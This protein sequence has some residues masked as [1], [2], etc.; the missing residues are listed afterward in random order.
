MGK[1]D[2]TK[3]RILERATPLLNRHGYMSAPLS[4][5]MRVTGMQKG[6]IYN[7][8]ASKEDLALEAFDYA[9]EVI[10]QRITQALEGKTGAIERLRAAAGVFRAYAD[11]A[12]FPGGCP[13]LNVAI[14][15]DDAHPALR[16]RARQ[17]MDRWHGLFERI[18]ARGI[19]RGELR[20]DV[21]PA[22]VATV[23]IAALEGA[24]AMTNLHKD[25]TPMRRIL[26]HLDSYFDREL[27]Q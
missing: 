20:A 6:G 1:G 14:E 22:T 19:E 18:V 27:R 3:R 26:A 25:G 5:I 10:S 9:I 24:V 7:H 12:P 23:T 17:T 15:S 4:D 2:D 16:R 8:F 21:D 11:G 13:L